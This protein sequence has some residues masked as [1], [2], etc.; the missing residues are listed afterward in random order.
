MDLIPKFFLEWKDVM[1]LAK[2]HKSL[3]HFKALLKEFTENSEKWS[4]I[5]AYHVLNHRYE[6]VTGIVKCNFSY[7]K[8]IPHWYVLLFCCSVY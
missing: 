8:K 4:H 7:Y 5:Y 3:M 6:Y 2:S 1:D